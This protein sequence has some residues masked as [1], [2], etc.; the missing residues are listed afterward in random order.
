M[1]R[2]LL[3]SLL[4]LALLVI[5]VPNS[6][7]PW[8]HTGDGNP[9]HRAPGLAGAWQAFQKLFTALRDALY[10]FAELT[11]D[12]LNKG[13]DAMPAR[14][15]VIYGMFFA[16]MGILAFVGLWSLLTLSRLPG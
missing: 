9:G 2:F 13:W 7:D 14:F 1:R 4:V 16:A 10:L 11:L 8:N 15:R 3:L 12:L 6:S 5:F